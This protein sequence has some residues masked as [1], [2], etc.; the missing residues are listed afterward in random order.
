MYIY[1]GC[2][3][4]KAIVTLFFSIFFQSLFSVGKFIHPYF[5]LHIKGLIF[6][7]VYIFFFLFMI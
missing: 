7:I 4:L 2:K 3:T 5:Y 1:L 6:V